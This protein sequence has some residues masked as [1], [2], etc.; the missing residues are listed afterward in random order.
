MYKSQEDVLFDTANSFHTLCKVC[1]HFLF[2]RHIGALK[3]AP[4]VFAPRYFTNHCN[5]LNSKP[6]GP[7][8]AGLE[9]SSKPINPPQH[10]A[11]AVEE[12]NFRSS[13]VQDLFIISGVQPWSQLRAHYQEQNRLLLLHMYFQKRVVVEW[14][15]R[16]SPTTLTKESFHQRSHLA[17]SLLI[18]ETALRAV[19]ILKDGKHDTC[20]TYRYASS[21]GEYEHEA[22]WRKTFLH[23][24]GWDLLFSLQH[25]VIGKES[26][27]ETFQVPVMEI[28]SSPSQVFMRAHHHYRNPASSIFRYVAKVQLSWNLNAKQGCW[29]G[30]KQSWGGRQQVLEFDVENTL[31]FYTDDSNPK[32]K[33]FGHTFYKEPI[34]LTFSKVHCSNLQKMECPNR[35]KMLDIAPL[36]MKYI[37]SYHEIYL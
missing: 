21:A 22:K 34:Y 8:A 9:D 2:L 18:L 12:Y 33:T 19:N 15:V 3:S 1:F 24:S 16:K 20:L 14:L 13:T 35:T 29:I 26:K 11:E 10:L 27:Q 5:L 28:P 25:T 31:L 32:L 37:V 23:N 36:I 6:I 17:V 30:Y 4:D 7:D